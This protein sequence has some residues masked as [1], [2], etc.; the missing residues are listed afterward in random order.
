MEMGKET[1]REMIGPPPTLVI[2]NDVIKE[3]R[4]G[5]RE[6]KWED[7]GRERT[8]V[9]PPRELF[10][11]WINHNKCEC[12]WGKK[13][14]KKNAPMSS[15]PPPPP[16]LF[17]PCSATCATFPNGVKEWKMMVKTIARLWLRKRRLISFIDVIRANQKKK[18]DCHRF[19]QIRSRNQSVRPSKIIACLKEVNISI[20]GKNGE[21]HLGLISFS[22]SQYG[23]FWTFTTPF[24]CQHLAAAPSSPFVLC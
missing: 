15:V 21:W 12:I 4:K 10:Q 22:Y 17:E 20:V 11:C 13:Y 5:E 9:Q 8:V 6:K 1:Q 14:I 2:T 23:V 7:R 18:T 24:N 16:R 19:C 3:G